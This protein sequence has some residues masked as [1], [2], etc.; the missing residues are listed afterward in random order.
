MY[1]TGD[2]DDLCLIFCLAFHWTRHVDFITCNIGLCIPGHCQSLIFRYRGIQRRYV[3]IRRGDA[4]LHVV[5]KLHLRQVDQ[6][7]GFFRTGDLNRYSLNSDL[8]SKIQD[9]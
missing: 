5:D 3:K 8:G 1:C 9:Q 4:V 2:T 6:R 7:L